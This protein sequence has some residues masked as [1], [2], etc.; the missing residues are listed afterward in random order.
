MGSTGIMTADE[1]SN[2]Q[3]RQPHRRR[4]I[5]WL[6]GAAALALLVGCGG[7]A[8]SGLGNE[9]LPATTRPTPTTIPVDTGPTIDFD[10]LPNQSS[11]PLPEDATATEVAAVVDDMRGPTDDISEQLARLAPFV[12]FETPTN[13]Q[14]TDLSLSV[15]TADE[16]QVRISARVALRSPLPPA[17]LAEHFDIDRRSEAWFMVSE[18][19]EIVDRA[20]RITQVYR[21][22]GRS[23][24][25]TEL[26]VTIT[27]GPFTVYE[28]D[29][30]VEIEPDAEDGADDDAADS[31]D[32]LASLL[33]W[34]E[35]IRLP[36]SADFVET[37]I[38]TADDLGKLE[39]VYEIPGETA[40]AVRENISR[41]VRPA[42]FET[43]ASDGSG[44]NAA[45]LV[46]VDTDQRRFL[47]EFAVTRE[48]ELIETIIST[49]FGLQPIDP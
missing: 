48:P 36:Q 7:E 21:K 39:V 25:E 46:L 4:A 44:E 37:R 40:A 45:P 6:L 23:G 16:E 35:A 20:A 31:V 3:Q 24:D 9:P 30:R 43:P 28:V 27:D 1:G 49:E 14:I 11:T 22:P 32:T 33:A 17:E 18:V 41:L 12:D 10:R 15:A 19:D 42:E 34:Q 5:I 13:S 2:P 47:V 8:S 26:T 38:S 29:Y